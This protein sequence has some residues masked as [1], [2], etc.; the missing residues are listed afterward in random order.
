MENSAAPA[1]PK[2]HRLSAYVP[3]IAAVAVLPW[4]VF[5][6]L[7]L[8]FMVG[9]TPYHNTAANE[10]TFGV[11]AAIVP[12]AGFAFGVFAAAT[13]RV[14]TPPQWVW[15]AVGMLACAIWCIG[16]TVG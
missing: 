5:L 15:F 4:I 1:A 9:D 14:R 8:L 12:A 6:F 11:L 16:L 2:E 13:G 7:G 3:L 10:L